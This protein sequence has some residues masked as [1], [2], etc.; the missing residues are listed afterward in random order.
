MYAYMT[1]GSMSFHLSFILPQLC[2]R[3][4]NPM[5]HECSL[6]GN[7]QSHVTCQ[8]NSS[9][10]PAHA[11]SAAFTAIMCSFSM[12]LRQPCTTMQVTSLRE[13][14]Q[15]AQKYNSQL[16]EY[17]TKLQQDVALSN[18]SLQKLQVYLTLPHS[19]CFQGHNN[20]ASCCQHS[21]TQSSA[22]ILIEREWHLQHLA[23][24]ASSLAFP[25]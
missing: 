12:H 21:K 17:N 19:A 11:H 14:H 6:F 24:V 4:A 13:L 1:A 23:G 7:A 5:L 10:H 8:R 25:C 20:L 18:D 3:S 2:I 9:C 15:Q 16:Q 22:C